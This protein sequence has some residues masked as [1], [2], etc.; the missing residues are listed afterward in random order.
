MN[1]QEILTS[2]GGA[3]VILMT[4]VQIAP[5]KINPWS[6]VGRWIG[7]V[8]NKEVM[9]KLGTI[10]ENQ[11]NT[12]EALDDHIRMDDE[13]NADL[14][15]VQILRFN[16]EL[17][18]NSLPHTQEDF[19]EALAEIDFYERYCREH[20]DYENNRA[21]LA[22]QNIKRVYKEKLENHDFS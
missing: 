20:Q 11:A 9:D 1:L 12:R 18:H 5:I 21:V 4:L 22:I 13:R 7:K 16:R 10:E 3:L 19:I 14:H 2:S 15:R 8:I 6:V 17:L